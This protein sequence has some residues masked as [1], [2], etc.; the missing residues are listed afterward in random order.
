MMFRVVNSFMDILATPLQPT[1][2]TTRGHTQRFLTPFCH[3]KSYQEPFFPA[4]IV[5]WNS[6]PQHIVEADS[7]VH[8]KPI[9]FYPLYKS[10]P[11]HVLSF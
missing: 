11:T 1:G 3:I 9:S 4:I 6:F 5:L 8:K 7:L 10:P 2:A